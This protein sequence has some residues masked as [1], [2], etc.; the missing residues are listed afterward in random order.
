MSGFGISGKITSANSSSV[1]AFSR[2]RTS[3]PEAIF[4]SQLQ[5]D[6]QPLVWETAIEGAGATL[7]VA[8]ES[9]LE[10]TVGTAMGDSV[11]R[12]TF[13]YCR[14]QPGKSQTVLMTGAIGAPKDNVR[15]RLGYFDGYDGLYFQ[16]DGY[17]LS[18]VLRDR[19]GGITNTVIPQSEWNIDKLNGNGA[20]QITVDISMSQ[21]FCID[22]QWLGVGRVRFG[23]MFGG[24]IVYCHEINN[25]N[26]R[27]TTYMSTANLP[28]R[29]EIE[30]TD[31]TTSATT[32][33]QICSTVVSEGGV[34][35]DKGFDHAAS[36]GITGAS[37]STRESVLSIRP[38]DIFGGVKNRGAIIPLDFELFVETQ[39][40][41][42]EIVYKGAVSSASWSSV[43]TNSIAEFS[44]TNDTVTGG[45]VIASGFV[46]AAA[47]KRS[48]LAAGALSFKP[49]LNSDILG[50]AQDE[51][52]IVCTALTGTA[53][54]RASIV[55]KERF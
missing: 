22:F 48:S 12:Q 25:S 35:E 36:T 54:V 30:N 9:A 7:H 38:K 39:A 31:N 43:G 37:I 23:F 14:Y 42:F 50:D 46:A 16:Q 24:D 29:Y 27:D 18:V 20:S 47:G 53:V 34:E 52:S 32:I 13:Q 8:E 55:F 10:L 19:N 1:D 3:D 49:S 41:F 28:V 45:E 44:T 5:Y 51:L 11:V 15:Q 33:K 26:M 4:E 6:D 2:W 21:I 40:I 17:T